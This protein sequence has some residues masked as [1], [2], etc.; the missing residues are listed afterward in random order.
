MSGIFQGGALLQGFDTSA[1]QGQMLSGNADQAISSLFESI[2]GTMSGL[3]D[4]HYLR[5]EYSN[6]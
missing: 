5:N 1:F 3:G 4:D 6:K 2:Y